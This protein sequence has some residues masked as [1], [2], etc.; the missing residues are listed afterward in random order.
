MHQ[1]F[2]RE[3]RNWYQA[4]TNFSIMIEME[5]KQL[6]SQSCSVKRCPRA[7]YLSPGLLY[8]PNVARWMS[9]GPLMVLFTEDMDQATAQGPQRLVDYLRPALRWCGWRTI[10]VDYALNGAAD[11]ILDQAVRRRIV[12]CLFNGKPCFPHYTSC[13]RTSM[14]WPTVVVLSRNV[15][16]RA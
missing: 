15:I 12:I 11:D 4:S 6:A 3:G 9:R 7:P 16:S 13:P 8:E 14:A 2:K 1:R 10:A 5:L